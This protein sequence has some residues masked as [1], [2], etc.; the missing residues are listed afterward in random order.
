MES[1]SSSSTAEALKT[2]E[3]RTG[4]P[5]GN[6]HADLI[7]DCC[8]SGMPSR[9]TE[10]RN[11]SVEIIASTGLEQSALGNSSDLA[12]IQNCTFTSRL[13][14]GVARSIGREDVTS[15]FFAEVVD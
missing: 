15:I 3:T 4:D 12:R 2:G 10:W 6:T 7:L 5:Q 13:A 8:V 9:G 14:D 1:H 11:R